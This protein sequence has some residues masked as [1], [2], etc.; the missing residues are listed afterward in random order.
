VSKS[1]LIGAG[2]GDNHRDEQVLFPS[3]QPGIEGN[4]YLMLCQ[5]STGMFLLTESH[6]R[7]IDGIPYITFALVG[8]LQDVLG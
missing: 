2:D 7:V 4:V 1:G 8:V 3:L 6:F 5:W